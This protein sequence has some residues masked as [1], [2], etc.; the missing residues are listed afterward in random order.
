M[1]MTYVF[2]SVGRMVA[3]KPS[4]GE[5]GTT[6]VVQRLFKSLPVRRQMHQNAKKRG[7]ELSRVQDLLMAFGL[8]LPTLRL[9]LRHNKSV[10]WQ[11]TKVSDCRS[12]FSVLFGSS[13]TS[14]MQTIELEMPELEMRVRG[15]LPRTDADPN[16]VMTSNSSHCVIAVNNRPV[17]WK[18]ALKVL[19]CSSSLIKRTLVLLLKTSV[20]CSCCVRR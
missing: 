5:R 15:I 17:D 3:S 10:V 12:A 2:N 6:V 1:G 7:D 20:G 19:D 8:I 11:K 16:K 9:E 14:Q 4:P 18:S 13:A